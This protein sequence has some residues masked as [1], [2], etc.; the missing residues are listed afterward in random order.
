MKEKNVLKNNGISIVIGVT[1]HRDIKDKDGDAIKQIVYDYI[2]SLK[3]KYSYTDFVMLNSLASGADTI[4]AEVSI[5][6]GINIICPLP[7][8]IDEYEKDF[9]GEDLV[10]F[11][12]LITKCS[13]TFVVNTNSLNREDG[14]FAAGRYVSEN[15]NLLIAIWDGMVNGKS[16]CGTGNI[17]KYTREQNVE[18]NKLLMSTRMVPIFHIKVEKTSSN[19]KSS[20]DKIYVDDIKDDFHEIDELNKDMK[21]KYIGEGYSIFPIN[22]MPQG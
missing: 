20:F 15:C 18:S 16:T 8:S 9:K 2:L 6:L 4:C 10:K 1:G 5:E 3:E 17:V 11:K 12:N 21:T 13:K 22:K 14:Y 19:S 7:F